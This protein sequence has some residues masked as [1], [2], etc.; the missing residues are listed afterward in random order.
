[1]YSKQYGDNIK[2]YYDEYFCVE[3]NSF[4]NLE[5]IKNQIESKILTK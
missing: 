5:V 2:Y 3:S 4:K 1:M